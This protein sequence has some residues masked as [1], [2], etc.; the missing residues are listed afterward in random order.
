MSASSLAHSTPGAPWQDAR[1]NLYE[2]T[3]LRQ[4]TH[5][6]G[7]AGSGQKEPILG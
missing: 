4:L 3:Y 2:P 7:N 5:S 1:H 6:A